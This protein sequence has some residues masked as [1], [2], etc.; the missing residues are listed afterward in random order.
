MALDRTQ[1]EYRSIER[2]LSPRL[3]DMLDKA[4]ETFQKEAP[5]EY[6]RDFDEEA[7]WKKVLEELPIS[8][9]EAVLLDIANS[10]WGGR[11]ITIPTIHLLGL[12]P[13]N[14][15]KFIIAMATYMKVDLKAVA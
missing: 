7:L 4:F 10:L 3:Q 13:D 12:D 15:K 14:R 6:D 2:L 5:D 9:Y 8:H 11:S 1:V